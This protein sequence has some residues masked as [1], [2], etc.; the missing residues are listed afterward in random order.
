MARYL[1]VHPQ[2][3]QQRSLNQAADLLRSGGIV[4]FP[5]DSGYALGCVLNNK[6]G[7]D[8]MRSIRDLS[9]HHHFTLMVSEFAALG[10]YVEM[11][12]VQF[13]AIKAVTPGKYTFILP[14]TRELPRAMLHPKKKTVGIRVPQHTTALALL[15]ALGQPLVST[16]LIMPGDDIPMVDGWQVYE[17]LEHRVAAVIDSGDAGH[18]PSTVVDWTGAAPEIVRI[19][20][21]DPSPF[22]D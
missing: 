7:L 14:A 4:A 19:G 16:T 3:P 18:E 1:D 11:N 6:D 2:N 15:E 8:R 5:T 17:A 10:Q 13:R 20:G 9:A 21:G 12:N 22:E